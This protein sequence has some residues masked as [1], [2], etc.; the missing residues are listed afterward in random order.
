MDH[1]NF[2]KNGVKMKENNTWMKVGLVLF[3]GAMT[4]GAWNS[5]G[6][7]KSLPYWGQ[8][9]IVVLMLIISFAVVKKE[10]KK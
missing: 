9:S 1:K 8:I 10:R 7:I 2:E 3:V 6:G 5:I 4:R